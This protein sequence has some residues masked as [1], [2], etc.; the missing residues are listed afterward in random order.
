MFFVI[1]LNLDIKNNILS[2]G[3]TLGLIWRLSRYGSGHPGIDSNDKHYLPSCMSKYRFFRVRISNLMSKNWLDSL[4]PAPGGPD[5]EA[6][7]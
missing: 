5:L 6:N 1:K 2:F 4:D 7:H 3:I